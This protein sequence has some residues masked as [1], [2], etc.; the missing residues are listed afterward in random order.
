MKIKDKMKLDDLYFGIVL[1]PLSYGY[2]DEKDRLVTYNL[3]GTARIKWAVARYITMKD[4]ERKKINDPLSFCFSD[5]WGRTEYE[6]IMCPWPYGD[7]DKVEAVGKKVDIYTMY[8]EPNAELLMDIVNRV[9][10]S[11]AKKY[12][13]DERKR[14]KR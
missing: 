1:H 6:F 14:F 5:V 8:V 10:I 3:F 12:I 4:E 11:S 7:G 2:E 13:S 9:T